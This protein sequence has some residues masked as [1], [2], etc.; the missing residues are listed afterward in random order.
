MNLENNIPINRLRFSPSMMKIKVRVINKKDIACTKSKSNGKYFSLI[1]ADE[2]G[3]ISATAFDN[4]AERFFSKFEVHELYYITNFRLERSKPGYDKLHEYYI[5]LMQ[6]TV[7]ERCEHKLKYTPIIVIANTSIGSE[8]DVI[9]VCKLADDIEEVN[10]RTG[11][12]IK[13]RRVILVDNSAA[14]ARL[15]EF[16]GK[17]FLL[18]TK[19]TKLQYN[20]ESPEAHKLRI[21][22]DNGGANIGIENLSG[23]HSFNVN[24]DGKREWI[25]LAEVVNRVYSGNCD[26]YFCLCV[27]NVIFS[28]NALY[29][30]CP[31]E[32]CYKKMV[33]RDNVYY[34][35]KCKRNYS[36][37]VHRFRFCANVSDPT[38]EQEITSFND[39]A[40]KL[41]G[42]KTAD[43][44]DMLNCNRNKYANMFEDIQYKTFVFKFQ[45][46]KEYFHDEVRL[47]TIV[48]NAQPVN[49]KDANA[50]LVRSITALCNVGI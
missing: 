22:Y 25:T 38:G 30:A 37:F 41:I 7:V 45:T 42:R 14:G 47:K 5:T 48:M 26:D 33:E 8:I 16:K 32:H 19:A 20:P 6:N 46:R 4:N 15:T 10:D 36:N 24:S 50:R 39:I 1:L 12:P 40:E 31:T 49:Y 34:C 17:R 27:I 9:G 29:K 23:V 43:I 21:W 2:S 35:E 28:S 13:K 3:K 11:Q 18:C 44:V